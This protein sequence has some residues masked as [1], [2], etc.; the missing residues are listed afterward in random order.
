[1]SPEISLSSTVYFAPQE[2]DISIVNLLS[3]TTTEGQ[4]TFSSEENLSI[5]K[6]GRCY[7]KN[8]KVDYTPDDRSA[9]FQNGQP[10]RILMSL[11]FNQINYITKQGILAGF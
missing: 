4:E 8:V 10:T 2:F 7:L 1:M 5:P 11:V 3:K 6:I 9:F